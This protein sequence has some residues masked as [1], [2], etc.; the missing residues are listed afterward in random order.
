M[1]RL[2]GDPSTRDQRTISEPDEA[3]EKQAV[4]AMAEKLRR[5]ADRF[6]HRRPREEAEG[7]RPGP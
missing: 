3:A 6:L 4:E 5:E 2:A 1:A 7:A